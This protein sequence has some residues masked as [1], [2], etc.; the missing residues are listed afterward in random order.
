MGTSKA[1]GPGRWNAAPLW[2]GSR[3]GGKSLSDQHGTGVP[4]PLLRRSRA[5]GTRPGGGS[6][7]S[8]RPSGRSRTTGTRTA[9]APAREQPRRWSIVV[10]RTTTMEHRRG[11]GSRPQN[12]TRTK[13][14]TSTTHPA[15]QAPAPAARDPGTH[16]ARAAPL[17]HGPG[18]ASPAPGASGT[19]EAC[20]ASGGEAARRD[21]NAVPARGP[22]DG[23][24]GAAS[25]GWIRGCPGAASSGWIRGCPGAASGG[26]IRGVSVRPHT[27]WMVLGRDRV[28]GRSPMR[29]P[30]EQDRNEAIPS[31]YTEKHATLRHHPSQPELGVYMLRLQQSLRSLAPWAGSP[32]RGACPMGHRLGG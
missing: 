28:R 13:R 9:P 21:A 12:R 16:S 11:Y 5:A 6:A 1:I 29:P 27:G 17:S 3:P 19:A 4:R 18:Y 23:C 14:T 24:P 7:R 15:I 20:G 31:T 10:V 22:D 26:W 32:R 2:A 30:P 8:A 25:S